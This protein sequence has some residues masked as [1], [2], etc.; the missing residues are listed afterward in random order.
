MAAGSFPLWLAASAP[1]ARQGSGGHTWPPSAAPP[2]DE[3]PRASHELR[4]TYASGGHCQTGLFT[5]GFAS[6]QC[7]IHPHPCREAL[8]C[9]TGQTVQAANWAACAL[10]YRLRRP[11]VC[12]RY[13]LGLA[14]NL[15]GQAHRLECPPLP[16]GA[17]GA[18]TRHL[19][20]EREQH[21][22]ERTRCFGRGGAS[23]ARRPTGCR[24]D[25]GPSDDGPG[26]CGCRRGLRLGRDAHCRLGGELFPEQSCPWGPLVARRYRG[27]P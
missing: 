3:P 14:R 15:G 18:P 7:P 21:P 12:L 5:C 4:A 23:A 10:T 24:T 16:A 20:G 9:V 25:I 27:R 19:R 13:R 22:A 17:G 11:R 6:K 8:R 26:P 1:T 2:L